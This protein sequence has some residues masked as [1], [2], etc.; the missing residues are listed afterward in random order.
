MTS[1]VR[2]RERTRSVCQR[3]GEAVIRFLLT[4]VPFRAGGVGKR[5]AR[6]TLVAMMRA[7]LVGLPLIASGAIIVALP[8]TGRRLFSLSGR[9]GPSLVDAI[10]IAVLLAGW[11]VIAAA[12]LGRRERVARRAGVWGLGVGVVLAAVGLTV[13]VWSV[14]GDHGAWWALGIVLAV[15][16]QIW[17]IALALPVVTTEV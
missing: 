2:G 4:R 10:G 8:D 14:A 12:V 1:T 9:H 11:L 17:A 5:F 15:L 13:I 16:P 6:H 3:K 7:L